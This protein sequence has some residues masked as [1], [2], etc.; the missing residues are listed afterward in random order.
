MAELH[1]LDKIDA[2]NNGIAANAGFP[3]GMD[4]DEVNNA[5]RALEGMVARWLADND[6]T[7]TSAGSGNAYTLATPNRTISAYFDGLDF[8]FE[9][10]HSNDGPSTLN[11]NSLGAKNIKHPSGN[12][13]SPGDLIA[14]A[15]YKVIYNGIEFKL[16]S[17]TIE[18]RTRRFY[19]T[20]DEPLAASTVLQGD[21]HI[22]NIDMEVAKHYAVQGSLMLVNSGGA[23]DFKGAFSFSQV[24]QHSAFTITM[25]NA[26]SPES[27]LV[28]SAVGGNVFQL[29]P[30]IANSTHIIKI[31]GVIL[32][33]ATLTSTLD[34]T[35]AQI[36]ASGTSTLKSGSYLQLTELG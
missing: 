17:P 23:S 16:V 36:A 29:T 28:D 8:T 4:P 10:N 12:N 21:N 5:A 25:G 15:I 7:L 30:S 35:W 2:N 6:G 27:L 11:V 14:G 26:S 9:A 19:K 24:A 31:E 34:L 3:E 20:A 18:E 33:H 32:T 22:A 13:M 1:D